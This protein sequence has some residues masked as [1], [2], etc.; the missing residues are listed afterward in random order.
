MIYLF[1]LLCLNLSGSVETK[2]KKYLEKY[3]LKHSYKV[4]DEFREFAKGV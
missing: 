2:I 1:F 4:P 3:Y